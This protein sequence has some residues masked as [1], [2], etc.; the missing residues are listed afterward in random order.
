MF[1]RRTRTDLKGAA[2]RARARERTEWAKV[3]KLPWTT[4]AGRQ[5]ET[6]DRRAHHHENNHLIFYWI[7]DE[8]VP[9][10]YVHHYIL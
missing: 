5:T 3:L 7:L 9:V 2:T 1:S 8:A 6:R 4:A 10:D